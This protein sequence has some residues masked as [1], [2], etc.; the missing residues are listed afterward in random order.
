MSSF[1]STFFAAIFAVGVFF[2]LD[3]F[4]LGVIAWPLSILSFFGAGTFL[5]TK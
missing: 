5:M 2:V 1:T 4:G 3:L